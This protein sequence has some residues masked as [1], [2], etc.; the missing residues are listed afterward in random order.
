M[1]ELD[2]KERE[3]ANR[4]IRYNSRQIDTHKREV[5]EEHSDI[6]RE[7]RQRGGREKYK[8]ERKEKRNRRTFWI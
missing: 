6:R 1:K 5:K 8:K 2:K 3:K 7:K 4:T